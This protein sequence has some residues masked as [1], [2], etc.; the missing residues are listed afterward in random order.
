MAVDFLVTDGLHGR[1][2][3]GL[4][5]VG[6]TFAGGLLAAGRD[7][8]AVREEIGTGA[9]VSAGAAAGGGA[10]LAFEM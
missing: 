6:L 8:N 5:P 1:G 9:A 3:L 7:G 2:V 4:V 10:N